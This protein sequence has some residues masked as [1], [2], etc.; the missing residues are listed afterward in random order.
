MHG[1]HVAL[2]LQGARAGS[3]AVMQACWDHKVTN[4]AMPVFPR[5]LKFH[6]FSLIEEVFFR[7]AFHGTGFKLNKTSKRTKTKIIGKLVAQSQYQTND[8]QL[9][10][11]GSQSCAFLRLDK[12]PPVSRNTISVSSRT[13]CN[14]QDQGIGLSQLL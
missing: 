6:D 13:L 12:L 14:Q 10:P 5:L 4:M 11:G 8:V 1:F 3:Q 9:S 7:I 2:L